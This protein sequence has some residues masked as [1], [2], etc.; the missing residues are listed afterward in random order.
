MENVSKRQ[1]YDHR[2]DNNKRT[3]DKGGRRTS[4][5]TISKI[6]SSETTEPLPTKLKTS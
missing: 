3:T 6:V 1:Q 2:A 5:V 4:S